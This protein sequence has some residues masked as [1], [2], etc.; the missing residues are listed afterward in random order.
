MSDIF[1]L[2]GREKCGKTPTIKLVLD[3][4]VKKYQI[5]QAQI[6]HLPNP[7]STNDIKVI[8]PPIQGYTVGIA[9]QGDVGKYFILDKI[10]ADF[11]NAKCDI[12]FCAC[13][14]SGKTVNCIKTITGYNPNFIKQTILPVGHAPQQETQS[15]TGVAQTM[16]KVAGL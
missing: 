3:E 13:R 2:Q 14:S 10:L 6:Q 5:Q 7:G 4:L 9:S 1:A 15:N 12:I 11:V 8:L 16:V